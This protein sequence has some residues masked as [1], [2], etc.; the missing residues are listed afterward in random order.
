MAQNGKRHVDSH[1]LT[2]LACGSTVEAAARQSGLS[3]ST[4]YRRLKNAAFCRRLKNLRTDMVQRAS[5]MLTA[6][7]MES[8][9]TL[10]ELQ[11]PTNTGP[12][13]LGAARSVLEMGVKLREVADLEQR[14]AALEMQL[15]GAGT[16]A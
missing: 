15:T 9:K 14:I 13:R 12:V 16:A 8:V 6:A 5:A 4:I 3:E 10:L 1:L 7:A 11:K 2:A